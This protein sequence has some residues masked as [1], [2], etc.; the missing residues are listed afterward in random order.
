MAYGEL[1]WRLRNDPRV[2]VLERANARALEPAD[3][4]RTRPT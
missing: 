3:A 2:T 4:A 1:H